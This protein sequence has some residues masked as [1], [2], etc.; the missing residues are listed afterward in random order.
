MVSFALAHVECAIWFY[1]SVR[2][3]AVQPCGGEADSDASGAAVQAARAHVGVIGPGDGSRRRPRV[4]AGAAPDADRPRCRP[5]RPTAEPVQQRAGHRGPA[6]RVGPPG[7]RNHPRKAPPLRA[8]PRPLPS[9]PPRAAV[10]QHAC[11][12]IPH[13]HASAA[14]LLGVWTPRCTLGPR[15]RRPNGV[16]FSIH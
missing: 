9:P 12:R 15:G 1:L 14:P 4:A 11:V 10:A 16:G 13:M 2:P 3:D 6:A 7:S 8:G 5:Q